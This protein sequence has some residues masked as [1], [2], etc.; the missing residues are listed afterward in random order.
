MKRLV[1][2]ADHPTVMHDKEIPV[3]MFA[4]PGR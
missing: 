3:Q 2:V 4:R 1:P